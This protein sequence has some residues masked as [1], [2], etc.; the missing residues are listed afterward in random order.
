MIYIGTS[1]FSYDDWKGHFYPKQFNKKNMLSYY[2]E[3]FNCVE[4]NSTYYKI[5]APSTFTA[6]DRNTPPEFH[7][8]VKAP[9]EMTHA[10]SPSE[11]IFDAFLASI[12]PIRQSNKLGC[13]LAQFP[14]SFSNTP[15]NIARLREFKNR[16]GEIPT[17]IEFRNESWITKDTFDFLRKLKLG[18][19]SVD[20][21]MLK[22]L[23]PHIA[24]ATSEIGYVRFHGRNAAKWW[25][26]DQPY[27]R[28]DYLYSEEELA[29]WIPKIR[30]VESKT[31][32]TYVFFNN[33]YQ[34]KSTQNARMLARMLDIT[35]PMDS[36]TPAVKQMTFDEDF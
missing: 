15:K 5:P 10:D 34:G 33:H 7:F 35:L 6:M 24:E 21:P 31:K 30:D 20:E 2:S 1:G 26:H 8:V 27:E 19:C 28:Y 14:W 13:V 12:E 9:H 17:V 25:K 36:Q 18:F 16:M 32:R 11:E 29:E 3:R 22:G 4:I 23:M